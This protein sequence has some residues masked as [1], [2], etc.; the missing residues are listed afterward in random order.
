[1]GMVMFHDL[2]PEVA[3]R[4]TRVAMIPPGN[5]VPPDTY[6][7]VDFYCVD[8]GCHCRRVMINVLVEGT[9]RHL[10]TI[11]HAFD[12]SNAD[13]VL[14]QTF[15][16]PLNTQTRWSDPLLRLFL[17]LL[18]D[19]DYSARLMRHYRLV[20]DAVD[21]PANPVH[22]RLAGVRAERKRAPRPWGRP[23]GRRRGRR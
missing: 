10:A 12:A 1:M 13:D 15:L 5:P 20:K 6:A 17:E 22:R 21:D 14:G 8:P 16:D 2:F 19:P 7:F 11:N 9:G 3:K 23:V 18:Q 4:E